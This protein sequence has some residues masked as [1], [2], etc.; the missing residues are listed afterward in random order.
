MK[1]N[2]EVNCLKLIHMYDFAF[3]LLLNK[4]SRLLLIKKKSSIEWEAAGCCEN[5]GEKIVSPFPAQRWFFG[6]P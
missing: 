4:Y 5:R 6:V 3:P 1:M 2:D